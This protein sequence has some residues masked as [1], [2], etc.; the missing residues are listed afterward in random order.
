MIKKNDVKKFNSL[1]TDEEK[2]K[3]VRELLEVIPPDKWCIGKRHDSDGKSCA[4]GHLELNANNILKRDNDI[5][6]S[7][8]IHKLAIVNNGWDWDFH[9]GSGLIDY[10]KYGKTPKER[11][12]NYLDELIKNAN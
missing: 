6:R 4:F 5:N 12:L 2:L 7:K 9:D 8:L 11:C 10:S 1:E 3:F